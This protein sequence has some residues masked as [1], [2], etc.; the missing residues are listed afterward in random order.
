MKAEEERKGNGRRIFVRFFKDMF[1]YKLCIEN[2]YDFCRL[3]FRVFF[4]FSDFLTVKE[5]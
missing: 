1:F 2:H 4:E 5:D 3:R